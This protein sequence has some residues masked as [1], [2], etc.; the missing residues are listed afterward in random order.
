MTASVYGKAYPKKAAYYVVTVEPA[1]QGDLH[2]TLSDAQD[3]VMAAEAQG[4]ATH[5]VV[6]FTDGT[7]RAVVL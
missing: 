6:V 1:T 5:T 4:L 3:T 2:H 7:E